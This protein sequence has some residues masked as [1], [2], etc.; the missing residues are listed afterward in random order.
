MLKSKK[1]KDQVEEAA[2]ELPG[3]VSCVAIERTVS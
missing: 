1:F 3:T 2:A